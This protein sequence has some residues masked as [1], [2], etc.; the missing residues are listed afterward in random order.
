M[1]WV[2]DKKKMRM[3]KKKKNHKREQCAEKWLGTVWV[4]NW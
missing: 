1:S 4:R 3:K 2:V